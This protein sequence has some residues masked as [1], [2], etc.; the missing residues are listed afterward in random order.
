MLRT[1]FLPAGMGQ[2][3]DFQ[4]E[5]FLLEV[6]GRIDEPPGES[7]PVLVKAPPRL[8]TVLF[9]SDI[10]N[11]RNGHSGEVC[12]REQYVQLLS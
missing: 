11:S 10:D 3:R 5:F 4:L 2:A 12:R 9:V 8:G 1:E 6:W 7:R